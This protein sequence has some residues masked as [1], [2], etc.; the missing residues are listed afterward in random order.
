GED[1]TQAFIDGAQAALAIIKE[2]GIKSVYLKSLSPSC[3]AGEIYDGTF[4]GR[5]VDGAGVT[6]ALL[7]KNGISVE[8]L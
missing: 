6:A 7:I 3:G 4:N 8:S 2:K 1:V 5:V